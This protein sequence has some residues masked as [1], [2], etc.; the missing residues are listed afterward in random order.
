MKFNF[1][2]FILVLISTDTFAQYPP[3]A[4]AKTIEAKD[5]T[6]PQCA[7]TVNAIDEQGAI[8]ASG[9]FQDSLRPDDNLINTY[10]V[11]NSNWDSGAFIKYDANGILI[12][13]KSIVARVGYFYV[14]DLDID[15]NH[16]VYLL[17]QGVYTDT[18]DFDPSAN[19]ANEISDGNDFF[20][21][22]YDQNGNYVW[23]KRINVINGNNTFSNSP[24]TIKVDDNQNIFI[25][26]RFQNQ[27]DLDPSAATLTIT[28]PGGVNCNCT[29]GFYAK[30]DSTGNVIWGFADVNNSSIN[31]ID[32][33][34]NNGQ[35]LIG[36]TG[37]SFSGQTLRLCNASGISLN[38]LSSARIQVN[39]VK[40]DNNGNFYFS[41]NFN[42][43]GNDFDWGTGSFIM[44][45]PASYETVGFVGKYDSLNNFQWAVEFDPTLDPAF[46]GIYYNVNIDAENIPIVAYGES[47]GNG[48]KKG[49]FKLD[50]NNGAIV[51]S[52]AMFSALV[53]LNGAVVMP[54][55]IDGSL[56]FS[57]GFGFTGSQT[58]TLDAAPDPNITNNISGIGYWSSLAKY[59]NCVAAPT[60]P[61]AI[62]GI[63]SLCNVDSVTFSV[64]LQLG[65]SSYSWILPAGWTGTTT[66]NSITVLPSANSGNI[67]VVA[68]NLCG[69]SAATSLQVNYIGVP[70]VV[71]NA[72][73]TQ[74]CIGDSIVLSGAGAD[75]Y[76]WGNNIIDGVAFA[77]TNSIDYIVTGTLNGCTNSDTIAIT[78]NPLPFVGLNLATIDTLCQ[79]AGVITLVGES[80]SGGVFSGIGVTANTFDALTSGMGNYTITYTYTDSNTCINTA[81]DSIF[82]DV[83]T[84]LE[85]NFLATN[86]T[87]YPNPG[88]NEFSIFT[89]EINNEIWVTDLLG[90]IIFP[91]FYNRTALNLNIAKSGVYI[92]F[93]KTE[94]G[95]SQKKLIVE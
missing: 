61:G 18:I 60:T 37:V 6:N 66:A 70:N 44:T 25:G 73:T 11:G 76:V 12:W 14:S 52:N 8:Y 58:S 65:V 13:A 22:K 83:C 36:A 26:G 43:L 2:I 41:G 84:G 77:P 69:A 46:D 51:G 45:T 28:N 42:S 9:Y 40:F 30:Y 64:P 50:E 10:L 85:N 20:L 68:N 90:K 63:A 91:K 78:V 72:N 75:T 79:N 17:C 87:L 49:F 15:Q 82:V 32:I 86:W 4:W 47:D 38:N 59:G 67:E 29:V 7:I 3:M 53:G 39:A 81:I 21:A 62:T 27:I 74:V 89:N 33:N 48:Y 56:V 23:S 80:P 34:E 16:N 54:S 5:Q 94:N 71:A 19:V 93:L 1:L 57:A 88:E 92:V 24:N 55:S 95:I 31:S 35:I